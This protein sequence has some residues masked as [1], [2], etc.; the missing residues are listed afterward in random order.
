MRFLFALAL[1]LLFSCSEDS[2]VDENPKD[3]GDEKTMTEAK[4]DWSYRAV[5]IEDK[6]WGYQLFEGARMQI[7]QRNIPAIN[8]LHYFESEEQAELAAA[9]ALEKIEQGFFPPT[10]S[11]LELDSIGAINLDS[12]NLVNDELM[13]V[14]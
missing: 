8:G 2:S 11:P 3:S 13:K 5:Q 14:N 9:L 12:I 6:G 1:L 7:D 4:N 10:V